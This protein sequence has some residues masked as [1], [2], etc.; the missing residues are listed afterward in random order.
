MIVVRIN[1]RGPYG[2]DRVISCP[3]GGGSSEYLE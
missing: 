1:D 2:T 3:R